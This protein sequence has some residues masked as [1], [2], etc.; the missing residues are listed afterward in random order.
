M[1]INKLKHA[2]ILYYHPSIN[3]FTDEYGN[4]LHDLSDLFPVWQ[5]EEW[6]W[7][8]EDGRLLDRKGNWCEL[9][10]SWEFEDPAFLYPSVENN[11]M[12]G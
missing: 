1:G 6:K 3:R 10:F 9:Y 2:Y 8:E 7:G 4:I 12:K 11:I 5:L